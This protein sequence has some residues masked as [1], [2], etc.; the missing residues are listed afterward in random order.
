[1]GVGEQV[2]L[3]ID[4][5]GVAEKGVVVAARG[6][7]FVEAVDDRANG[8][9]GGSV[10]RHRVRCRQGERAGQAGKEGR[11]GDCWPAMK[12]FGQV[13]ASAPNTN[14]QRRNRRRKLA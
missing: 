10:L 9:V 8:G 14:L 1:M 11:D 5:K 12:G 7:G 2:A 13:Q 4:E 6:G 3:L